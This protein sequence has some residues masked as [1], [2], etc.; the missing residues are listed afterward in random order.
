MKNKKRC[1]IFKFIFTVS[2]L[3]IFLGLLGIVES[4]PSSTM[5]TS[6]SF[7]QTPLLNQNTDLTV[8]LLSII[9]ATNTL[10]NITFPPEIKLVSGSIQWNVSLLENIISNHTITVK[11]NSTGNFSI[12]GANIT[13][14]NDYI[15][16]QDSVSICETSIIERGGIG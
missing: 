10:T 8:E 14:F 6:I 1:L 4:T 3:I 7:N 11:I 15:F 2:A 9:N 13:G 16:K 12:F 5:S